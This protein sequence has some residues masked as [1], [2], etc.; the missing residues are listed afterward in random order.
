MLD[1]LHLKNFAANASFPHPEKVFSLKTCQRHLLI[2]LGDF[3]SPL[4]S[5][6]KEIVTR[7]GEAAYH[8]LLEVICGIQSHM[9]AENEIV[10]QFKQAYG[11]YLQKA[12]RQNGLIRILEKLFKD[13]KDVRTHYLAGVGQKTYAAITRKLIFERAIPKRILIIGTGQLALD[14][15]NQFKK[16]VEQIFISSR[17][18]QKVHEF[19]HHYLAHPLQWRDFELYREFPFIVNTIGVKGLVLLGPDFFRDWQFFHPK[20]M[21]VDLG[22]PSII[23]TDLGVTEGVIRLDHIF[24]QSAIREKEKLQRI[25]QAQMAIKVVAQKRRQHFLKPTRGSQFV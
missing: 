20:K 8:Y 10:G 13:A 22:H 1:Q 7:Q 3:P 21:F 12:D 9:L 16:R 14:M 15:A 2:G 24:K 18:I 4:A 11:E 19:C 23:K 17:N 25:Q 6:T 5:P